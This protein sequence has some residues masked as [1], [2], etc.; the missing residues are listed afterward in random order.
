MGRKQS[1]KKLAVIL[2]CGACMFQMAV[3]PA[4]AETS[5]ESPYLWETFADENTDTVEDIATPR[6]RGDV[7]NRGYIKLTNKDGKAAIYGETLGIYKSDEIGLELY[8]E[9]YNGT[10]FSSYADWSY[11]KHNVYTTEAS[12]TVSVPKGYYYSL[13]GYHYVKN[14]GLH[15]S[16]GTATSGLQIK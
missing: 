13:R 8:L 1:L 5:E 15:E 7:L 12:L 10:T 4:A 9:K 11:V 3:I 2:A 16:V 6:A 14:D